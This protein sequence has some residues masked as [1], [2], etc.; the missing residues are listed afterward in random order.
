MNR[1]YRVNV[2]S[3]RNDTAK[4]PNV[5]PSPT[6]A[7]AGN[8]NNDFRIASRSDSQSRIR[9]GRRFRRLTSAYVLDVTQKQQDFLKNT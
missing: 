2:K 1:L 8:I 3:K 7:A 6:H 9:S 4:F 5:M